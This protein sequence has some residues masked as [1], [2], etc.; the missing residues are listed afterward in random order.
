MSRNEE[1]FNESVLEVI[2]PQASLEFPT[3]YDGDRAAGWLTRLSADGVD[4]RIAFFD[5]NLD[6]LLTARFPHHAFSDEEPEEAPRPPIQLLSFLAHLQISYDASYISPSAALAT[7]TP[8]PE[9]ARPPIPPRTTSIGPNKPGLLLAVHPSIFPPSTPHPIPAAAESDRKYVQAKGTPLAAGVWGEGA[10]GA[11]GDASEAF[12][13][14]WAREDREW[15][16]VYK[17]AVLV[18]FMQTRVPDPLLCLTVSTT[19]RD[20][21]LP[22]TLPL[23]PLL[24]LINDAG[25]FPHAL[26]HTP[27][28]VKVNGTGNGVNQGVEGDKGDVHL[29]GLEEINLL[30]G[31]AAGPTF[32]SPSHPLNLPS[33]R[34]GSATRQSTFSLPSSNTTMT[35]AALVDQRPHSTVLS[36]APSPTLLSPGSRGSLARAPASATM[37]KSFRKTMD[38]ASGFRV[39]MRTVFVP[40]FLLPEARKRVD[41]RDPGRVDD[42]EDLDDTLV[43]EQREAGN[44]EHTVVLSV[45]I[46]NAFTDPSTSTPAFSFSVESAEVSVGGTGARTVLVSWGTD[47][48][49]ADVFPLQIG[50][51]EQVNLLYAVS[52][53]RAPEADDFSLAKAPRA[54]VKNGVDK[55]LQRSVTINIKGRPFQP[56][57]TSVSDGDAA[58]KP[59][60]SDVSYPTHTYPSRWNCV[61]DLSSNPSSDTAAASDLPGLEAPVPSAHP[62]PA[63]PFP[64]T[65]APNSS[66]PSTARGLFSIGQAIPPSPAPRGTQNLTPAVA[67][68]KRYTFSALDTPAAS[69][70]DS[71]GQK[72]PRSPVNYQGSTAML[73]P[74]NQPLTDTA[75][76]TPVGLNPIA[77]A[78]RA[79]IPPSVAFPSTYTRSPT[80][81]GAP[82]SPPPMMQSFGALG[83]SLA[84]AHSHA[85]SMASDTEPPVPRTPAYPAY[86]GSPP[87]VPPTPFWQG[88]L[89]QQTGVGAVGPSVEIRR[90]RAGVPPTPGPRVGGFG[91][92]NEVGAGIAASGNAG[93]EPIVVSVGLLPLVR[94]KGKGKG[95]S[96]GRRPGEI[97]PLDQFTLDIFVFNQSSW[98]R[99]FEVSYP[100]ERRRRRR[101]NGLQKWDATTASPG[102]LPLENGV[103]IGP[104]LPSTC[105]S[106]RMD[107][108]ALTPGVHAIDTVTLTDVQTGFT[109]HL[110]SVMDIV[111]HEMNDIAR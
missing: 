89:A 65:P 77:S 5:E 105:Q 12:A 17:M 107:F 11:A 36:S 103:R 34:L 22:E 82:M 64:S 54:G 109:M 69:L 8:P 99:R 30:S 80:T 39:R 43:R 35:S 94:S 57:P 33:T 50:P 58:V 29:S 96:D 98:T 31:L 45:E 15:I 40:Y 46:E 56:T 14:L 3:D 37:R 27:S 28:A 83:A 88:P 24:A 76:T 2:A 95:N 59:E 19:L 104:L 62:M 20:K 85:D 111:V 63:S 61:L 32:Q 106:V 41:T 86:P 81:Y 47:G 97:Y 93:G 72:I 101:G 90:D 60:D 38:T 10:I 53:L 4:R 91:M 100:E 25:G 44:E 13:L 71:I 87:P 74:A 78:G 18:S 92:G 16:A 70:P 7:S 73:N 21:P 42:S 75:P 52:F 48:P 79:Y 55:E 49:L 23:Q 6:F 84:Q 26:D 9:L 68:S 102:I 1:L 66:G 67:G 51:R 108:L 110:R